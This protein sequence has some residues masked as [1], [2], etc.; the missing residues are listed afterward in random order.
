MT[1]RGP[2]RIVLRDCLAKATVPTLLATAAAVA[3]P[4]LQPA[5]GG[6]VAPGASAPA[7]AL[8]FLIAAFVCSLRTVRIWP[9]F[10]LQ[11]PGADFVQRLQG[12]PWRGR[13]AAIAAALTA[14]LLLTMPVALLLPGWLG[15][16]ALA[17]TTATLVAVGDPRLDRG[18][19][20]V[21]FRA[22]A[23]VTWQRI[24]LRAV[25]MLPDGPV[26]PT[27]LSL[28]ADGSELAGGLA[29]VGET[30]QR[31][32]ATFPP[33]QFTQVEVALVDGTLPLYF[34]PGAVEAL[35]IEDR[36]NRGNAA[37]AALIALLPT[38]TALALACLVGFVAALP[39]V[40]TVAAS[41]LFVTTVGGVEPFGGAFR[42]V[43]RGEWLFGW[44][45]F[46]A[47]LPLLTLGSLAMALAMVA[48]TR[49][50]A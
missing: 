31:L 39:T 48:R 29:P 21:T 44:E 50:R 24:A 22:P 14:Q 7:L 30:G 26:R 2:F 34:P 9:L 45:V 42:A 32:V 4:R 41:L 46:A 1:G 37:L 18:H 35:S 25:V 15:A 12:G 17:H 38:F 16:P 28:Q 10:A 40:T 43:M 13:G 36:D 49:L 47:G 3:W 33:R 6:V 27:R 20:Q 19:P 11:R 5:T 23:D 8:P